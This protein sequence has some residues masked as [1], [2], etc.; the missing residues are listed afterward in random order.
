MLLAPLAFLRRPRTPIISGAASHILRGALGLSLA[1][2]ILL[3]PLS[4][5]VPGFVTTAKTWQVK[6]SASRGSFLFDNHLHEKSNTTT[7]DLDSFIIESKNGVSVCREARPEEVLS[8]LPRPDDRRTPVKIN[9]FSESSASVTSLGVENA[10]GPLT[11]NL[12]ALSQLDSDPDKATVI[13]AVQ[14]AAA[15]WTARIK[16]P[17]TVTLNIDYGVNSPGGTA[18]PTGVLGSTSSRLVQIDYPGLRTNLNASASSPAEAS[19]YAAL[20]SGVVPTDAGNGGV[21]VVSRSLARQLGI[22]VPSTPA[23]DATIGFNKNV[24]FDFNPDDGINP[25][26]TDFVAVATHEIGHALGFTSGAGVSQTSAVRVWDLFRFRPGTTLGTFSTA[27]RVMTVGGGA[28]VYFTGQSFQTFSVPTQSTPATPNG[29]TLE[30]GLSTGGPVPVT[31]NGGDGRQSSHWKADELSGVHVGIMDPTISNGVRQNP[32]END[33][34]T[35]ETLGWDLTGNAPIPPPPPPPPAPS[36]DNF[37]SAQVLSGCSGNVTGTN[38]GATK[39]AGELDNPDS[40]GSLRSVWYQ[41]QAP[42]TGTVTID[43]IGSGFDSVV[44]VYTG[45]SLGSLSLVAHNDDMPEDPNTPEHEVWS[46]LSF[47]A[48]Q[49]TTYRIQVNGF[50]NSGSLGDIGSIQLNWTESPCSQ[51]APPTILTEDGAPTK[52]AALDSVTFVRGPFKVINPNNFSSDQ[53]TRVILFTSNLGSSPNVTVTAN[54]TSLAV[55]NVGS[56]S[57]VA[58]LDASYIIVR[59]PTGLATGELPLVVT[60]NGVASSNSPLLSVSQ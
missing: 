1:S 15:N 23:D 31:T 42:S 27:Q 21:G 58:G 6:T 16:S 47:A 39:E 53:L 13:A 38:V 55:E 40:P 56:L 19:I 34:S 50:D 51:Q 9:H 37:T 49:G 29:T 24:A 35:L 46:L 32:T 11:I 18:F 30:P 52:A 25:F 5:A 14:R 57:G 59:L 44:A 54:G 8:T 41:W 7:T 48:T 12:V 3:A 4:F 45:N 43:T 33:F 26:L 22:P 20:P 10:S 60:L 36:N 28:Q 2:L 17:T